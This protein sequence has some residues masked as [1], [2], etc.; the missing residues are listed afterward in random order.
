[1]PAFLRT[2]ASRAAPALRQ[3]TMIQRAHFA[4]EPIASKPAKGKVGVVETIVGLG[5]LSLAI[6]GPSGWILVN[7]ENY[8]NKQ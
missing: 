1:M 3:H 2:L 6:L 5:M 4:T 8:K 7:I